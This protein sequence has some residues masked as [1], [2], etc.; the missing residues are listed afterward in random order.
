MSQTTETL[1]LNIFRNH[2]P[3]ENRSALSIDTALE[4]TGID[5]LSMAEIIFEIE[6][7]FDVTMPEP[8]AAISA[9]FQTL[10][11]IHDMVVRALAAKKSIAA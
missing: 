3:A 5:S 2:C 10:R 8:D 7:T 9:E 6:D 1:L 4:A 11:E